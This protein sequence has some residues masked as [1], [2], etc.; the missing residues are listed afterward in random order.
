M[1][2]GVEQGR[3]Q[4]FALAQGFGLAGLFKCA[5]QLVVKSSDLK[6]SARRFLGAFTGVGR[7][8]A[9][10]D[11]RQ[12][13][14]KPRDE[15]LRIGNCPG[16]VRPKEKIIK[17]EHRDQGGE[18]R[19]ISAEKRRARQYDKQKGKRDG[20]RVYFLVK[21]FE[22]RGDEQHGEHRNA[23]TDNFF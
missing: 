18:K 22:Q 17:A 16:F 1:R 15:I 14:R 2:D 23:E 21:R 11:R 8:L 19:R 9:R 12:R 3:F 5:L 4:F 6:F 10:D 20:R 13:E 7:K